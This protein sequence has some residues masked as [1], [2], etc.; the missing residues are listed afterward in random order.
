MRPDVSRIQEQ[1]RERLI[2]PD[3]RILSFKLH[4][5][6]VFREEIDINVL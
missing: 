5:T 4:D 3:D 2:F 1:V 6:G